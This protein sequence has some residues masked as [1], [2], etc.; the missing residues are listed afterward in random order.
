MRGV[1]GKGA[2]VVSGH[3]RVGVAVLLVGVT[4]LA[5][6]VLLALGGPSRAAAFT[7]QGVVAGPP[8]LPDGRLYEQVSPSNKNGTSAGTFN[9]NGEG[10]FSIAAANGDAVVY[11]AGGAFAGA[12][13]APLLQPY[14]AHRGPD[15]WQSTAATPGA[16]KEVGTVARKIETLLVATETFDRFAFDSAGNTS[17]AAADPILDGL[18]I[19]LSESP[20]VE[21]TWLARPTIEEPI[22]APG[23]HVAGENLPDLAGGTPDLSTVYFT[24]AGTLVPE[25]A[26]RAPNV[27]GGK[28]R[29]GPEQ[30][31]DA[32][33]F[34]EWHEGNLKAAGVLPDGSLNPFGAV[35]AS[36][37]G[38]RRDGKGYEH[39]QAEELDNEVSANGTRAF[40]VSPDPETS[41]VTDSE[42]CKLAGPC[43][44]EPPELYVRETQPG[45]GKRTLLVSRSELAG[46]EGE[47]APEGASAVS[48]AAQEPS[49]SSFRPSS[50]AFAAPN[51][52]R[53]FFLSKSRL[54]SQAPA[55][56]TLKE[57]EFNVETEALTYLPAVHGEIL[58]ASREGSSLLFDETQAEPQALDIWREGAD[59]GQVTTVADLPGAIMPPSEPP[60]GGA[61]TGVD[62]A[63]ASA[64]GSVFL[65]RTNSPIAGG[66]NNGGGYA[67]IYRYATDGEEL[68]CVSCA[69]AGVAPSGNANVTYDDYVEHSVTGHAG[70][71]AVQDSLAIS[72]DGERVFFDTPNALAPQAVDG[73]RNVYEWE[74]GRVYLISSGTSEEGSFVLSSSASG[75]DVFF[76]TS[77]GL[78]P[79]D[80]DGAYD[81]YDARV[82][83]P[84][85]SSPL[86]ASPCSGDQCQGPPSTPQLLTAPAS[87]TFSGVGNESASLVGS[88]PP[89]KKPLAKRRKSKKKKRKA[90]RGKSK[91]GSS[92]IK[93][94]GR[95]K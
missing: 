61:D 75:D 54:T 4:V 52:S 20:A 17:Y 93:R 48:D 37:A 31:S 79:G 76:A 33:G 26:S 30:G 23:Q 29:K 1:Y 18:H 80:T 49:S 70:T 74:D 89:H 21:P 83:Q 51:G 28:G 35:P 7:A 86:P 59:G 87:A 66:F 68:T 22:P 50:Y 3:R 67:Q 64:D 12:T 82:P 63:R 47:A 73:Q 71:P 78:V 62:S 91:R 19:Y 94:N 95:G 25:D 88:S 24:Y 46:H 11:F 15:G 34:Y 6:Y 60:F 45:G 2:Y 8:G 92:K 14:V 84:G 40:F 27:D 65:F 77:Q 38:I 16:L 13:S 85:D 72:E 57:Y 53:V 44:G 90:S 42:G 9:G 10:A 56:E 81:V 43:T 69:P 36:L 32:W 41:T 55:D 58:A 39:E 5:A